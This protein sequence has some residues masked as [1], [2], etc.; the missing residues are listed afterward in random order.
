ME[1]AAHQEDDPRTT[2][3]PVSG[4]VDRTHAGPTAED[5]I[6]ARSLDLLV[7]GL[8][9]AERPAARRQFAAK[10]ADIYTR[11]GVEIPPWLAQEAGGHEAER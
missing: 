7:R 2:P 3:P 6:G 4:R 11:F 8:P 10:L 9:P 1:D 5:P